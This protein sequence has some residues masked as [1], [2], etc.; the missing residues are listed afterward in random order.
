MLS[1]IRSAF[2]WA[3]DSYVIFVVIGLVIGLA[4]APAAIQFS[5]G[6]DGT[7]AVVVVDG[8]IDGQESA[9][10]NSAM[11]EARSDADAVVVIANSG[12]GS[13]AASEDMYMQTVRTAEEMPVV[14]AVDAA[15]ASG[16]YY[17]IAPADEI[18]T[19]PS[20]VIGSVGVLAQLPPEIEPNNLIGSTG[21]QKI[22]SDERA[23]FYDL[24]TLGDSFVGAVMEHRGDRI[25]LSEDEVAAA[26]T[27]VGIGA[28][29]NGLADE[30]GDREA[31][32]RDAADRADLDRPEVRVLRPD[33]TESS[34]LLESTYLA[35]TADQKQM[36]SIDYMTEERSD[37]PNY[38]MVPEGVV[39]DEIDAV[40]DTEAEAVTDELETTGED[41]TQNETATAEVDPGS[42]AIREAGT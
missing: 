10:Y 14:A 29:D 23:F 32:I 42:E 4:I 2:R 8:S 1:R 30:V 7:V 3:V 21:P 12:G 9:V 31:A 36:E 34:F 17:A 11:S 6:P 18:Y 16:A 25:E 28:V 37:P 33:G 15:A 39:A 13:A 38:L 20:S 27:Y 5:G 26:E 19:K 41:R 40:S 35:S 22:G 24:N